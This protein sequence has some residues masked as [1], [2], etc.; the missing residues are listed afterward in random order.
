MIEDVHYKYGENQLVCDGQLVIQ[1]KISGE[2]GWNHITSCSKVNNGDKKNEWGKFLHYTVNIHYPNES[3]N[4]G[5][6]GKGGRGTG[7]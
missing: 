3:K 4:F 6:R 2:V 1:N 5:K 7:L